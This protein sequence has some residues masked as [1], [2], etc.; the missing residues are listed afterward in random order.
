VYVDDRLTPVTDT[1]IMEGMLLQITCADGCRVQVSDG[2]NTCFVNVGREKETTEA[3]C[4]KINNSATVTDLINSI[5]V[6]NDF[7][8]DYEWDYENKR[9]MVS[10][11]TD[12]FYFLHPGSLHERVF[13]SKDLNSVLG[14]LERE[15]LKRQAMKKKL[16]V[17]NFE[18]IDMGELIG[19]TS[20]GGVAVTEE[21]VLQKEP[22][23]N[24]PNGLTPFGNSDIGNLGGVIPGR[25]NDT[26]GLNK[27]IMKDDWL[28]FPLLDTEDVP[29]GGGLFETFDEFMEK[30]RIYLMQTAKKKKISFKVSHTDQAKVTLT[31]C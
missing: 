13:R 16:E 8:F 20:T 6:F 29:S 24:N 19:I 28:K 23:T 4:R 27:C 31:I 12:E 9:L 7:G 17:A 30:C 14:N 15:T 25:K 22:I 1:T 10:L 21:I 3:L 5:F 2:M 11:E 18:G 26:S